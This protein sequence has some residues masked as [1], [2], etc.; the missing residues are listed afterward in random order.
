MRYFQVG[1]N[2][3]PI[4]CLISS[5]F[6][7]NSRGGDG[8]NKAN[9]VDLGVG[10]VVSAS[11]EFTRQQLQYLLFRRINPATA[12]L[13]RERSDYDLRKNKADNLQNWQVL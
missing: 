5:N 2:K 8:G 4:I 3:K 1:V 11:A 6:L 10:R 9:A 12:G 13:T 7:Y